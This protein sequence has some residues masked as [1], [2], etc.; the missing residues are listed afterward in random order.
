M[1]HGLREA[2]ADSGA[3]SLLCE[4]TRMAMKMRPCKTNVLR[5]RNELVAGLLLHL[6][7]GR[8]ERSVQAE[9]RWRCGPTRSAGSARRRR[10]KG[11]TKRYLIFSI[12]N[13]QHSLPA[14]RKVTR[15][16]RDCAR[17]QPQRRHHSSVAPFVAPLCVFAWRTGR[18]STKLAS[19][20]PILFGTSRFGW[21]GCP[22]YVTAV[23][24]AVG[25]GPAPRSS[26]RRNGLSIVP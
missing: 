18:I 9:R 26:R 24:R 1:G 13:R 17:N 10:G 7:S 5:R 21:P 6:D 11:V 16:Q 15:K 3:E 14:A 23:Y 4:E 8:G 19:L 22:G 25:T 12:Q 20:G 2:G